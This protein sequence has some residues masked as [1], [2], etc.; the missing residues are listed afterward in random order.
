[1]WE[2]IVLG[3]PKDEE[4]VASEALV[5]TRY[6]TVS[7]IKQLVYE[8]KK[9]ISTRELKDYVCIVSSGKAQRGKM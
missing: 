9:K 5:Q 4:V 1:M 2:Q 3:A 6:N 7:T 8:K